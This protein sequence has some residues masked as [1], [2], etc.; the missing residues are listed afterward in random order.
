MVRDP[1]S[2]PW[3]WL[4]G[5]G[6]EAGESAEDAAR[7]ELREE[8]GAELG[9]ARLVARYD[10]SYPSGTWTLVVF[11]G[12]ARDADGRARWIDVED[13]ALHPTVRRMLADEDDARAHGVE[14]ALAAIGAVMRRL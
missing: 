11:R 8:T 13:T 1:E 9:P 12:D 6:V 2:A 10:V 5:G 4:P 14:D 7:R 3:W